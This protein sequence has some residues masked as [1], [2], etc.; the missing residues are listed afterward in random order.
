MGF[1]HDQVGVAVPEHLIQQGRRNL[2]FLGARMHQD[3]RAKQR[4]DGFLQ[5]AHAAG[6]VAKVAEHPDTASAEIGSM[7]LAEALRLHPDTDGIAC[8]N[9]HI[10]LGALFACERRK[11]AVPDRLAV[12][13]FGDL[14]FSAAC[15][16]P[17][18]TIRPSGDLIGREAARLI[19]DHLNGEKPTESRMIDTRFTL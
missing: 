15:N 3:R 17:L 9:D 11:I 5:A 13:G 16:P 12:V 10:A 2:V 6:A 4:C 14:S 7:L 19:E 1:H 8:S 18:T